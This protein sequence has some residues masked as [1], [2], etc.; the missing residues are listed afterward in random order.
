[1]QKWAPMVIQIYI[2]MVDRR[3]TERRHLTEL[4]LK[5]YKLEN[6]TEYLISGVGQMSHSVKCRRIHIDIQ[7][8]E[9]EELFV[10]VAYRNR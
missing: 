8:D 10:R 5:G 3:L 7:I 2:L 1:M 4:Y 9:S 6:F